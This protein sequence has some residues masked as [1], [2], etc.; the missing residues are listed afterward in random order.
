[1]T[2][3]KRLTEQLHRALPGDEQQRPAVAAFNSSI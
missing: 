1:M 3:T 2:D